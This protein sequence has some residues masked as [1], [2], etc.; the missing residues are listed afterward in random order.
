MILCFFVGGGRL[1]YALS[2]AGLISRSNA[3][4]HWLALA[5]AVVGGAL[6]P[7]RAVG[8]LALGC[9]SWAQAWVGW[10]MFRYD[11]NAVIAIT[12]DMQRA[13]GERATLPA[14]H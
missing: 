12:P 2:S 11:P 6:I 1:S 3:H 9:V 10:R 13:L 5:I 4:L 8:L 7:G 14:P